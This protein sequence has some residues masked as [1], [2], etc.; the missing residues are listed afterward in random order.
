[1]ACGL[2]ALFWNAFPEMPRFF[3]VALNLPNAE[4]VYDYHLD[5]A[6]QDI[7]LEI[8]ALVLVPFGTQRVQGVIWQ[9][10]ESPTV[11]ST[12]PIERILESHSV[13][14]PWLLKLAQ[15][16][17]EETLTPLGEWIGFLLPEG[18]KQRSDWL[19]GW[20]GVAAVVKL[21]PLQKQVVAAIQEKGTLRGSQLDRRFK[22]QDWRR[23]LQPLIRKGYLEVQPLL[24]TP[25]VG[26][27]RA[28]VVSLA[29]QPSEFDAFFERVAK[30]WGKL[31]LER[32]KKVLQFLAQEGTAVEIAWVFAECG[33]NATDLKTLAKLGAIR[34]EERVQWRD[35]LASK[36][37]ISSPPFE[38]TPEQAAAWEVILPA[39]HRAWQ[40]QATQPIL[41]QG[42]TG[43]GKTE[44][45]LR[46]V[47]E[48]LKA[49]RQAVVLVPEISLTPQTIERFASRFVGSVGVY[50]SRLSFGERFDMWQRCRMGQLSVIVGARSALFMPFP[51]PGLVVVD[52]C[53][54]SSYYQ[55]SSPNYHALPAA[56]AYMQIAGGA[57]LFGSATPSIE[58][59]YWVHQGLWQGITLTRRIL[60]HAQSSKQPAPA[61]KP[62]SALQTGFAFDERQLSAVKIVD[63]RAELKQ[64]NRSIFSRLLSERLHQVLAAGQQAIL[65]LNRRGLATYVFCRDCGYVVKCPRC[66]IPLTAHSAEHTQ[67][68]TPLLCHHC[69]YRRMSPQRCPNCGSPHIRQMGIGTQRVEEEVRRVFPHARL[70]RW[71]ADTTRQKG[72]H[73]RIL[74]R[75]SRHEADILIGTQMLAKGLDLPMVTLVGVIL[76]EVGLYLPDFRAA[77]RTFQLL[78]QVAGRAGR[79]TL[80][81][82]AILQ[83]YQPD[84]YAIQAAALQDYEL[85]YQQEIQRRQK[86]QY[87]P[88]AQIVRLEYRHLQAEAAQREAQRQYQELQSWLAQDQ[89]APLRISGPLPCYFTR[90]AGWY[91]W[92]ILLIG[93]QP[94]QF[95]RHRTLR[96]GWRIEINPISLL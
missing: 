64:G 6:D 56:I 11:T 13:L 85:F 79:S 10:I 30:R 60:S 54:D 39:L 37:L 16:L 86:I 71:D 96:K 58:Q 15:R 59:S 17:A 45:Y 8:G 46:A 48:T 4:D 43:S 19:Y 55:D 34:L 41:L 57:C 18:Y 91:R 23:A 52:E 68:P 1:M 88:F 67:K 42:V 21:T 36:P 50:H 94:Q 84:H 2:P 77:E 22:H 63:M 31:S 78:T 26:T 62:G 74:D 51:K 80:G 20:K 27:K 14:T 33:A 82:E 29:L 40:G 75:F 83:T 9:E 70:L 72:A 28:R 44:V 61:Q 81:G 35:P 25:R 32:R 73:E 53:H 93:E 12:R 49:G 76:A 90:L 24:V 95:L 38:L 65:F 47:E 3:Q 69:G 87:P 7:H 5:Q 89:N 66:Q 92:Q